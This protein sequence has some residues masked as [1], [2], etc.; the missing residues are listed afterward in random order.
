MLEQWGL[1]PETLYLNH[2]TV[3]ATPRRVLEAQHAIHREIER[4]PSRFM[5]RELTQIGHGPVPDRPRR[6]RVAAKAVAEFFNA[7]GDDLVFVDNATTGCNAVIQSQ[8]FQPG[9]EIVVTDLTY[10]AIFNAATYAARR[11]GAKVIRAEIPYPFR[12]DTARD[13]VL[14]VL[15]PK[16]KL[17]IVDHITSESALIMPLA[18]LVQRIHERGI[19][20]LVDAAHAPGAIAVDIPSFGADWYVGN[21]HKWAWAPRSSGILWCHPKRQAET[22]PTVISWGLDQGFTWEFDLVGTRDPSPYLAAPVALDFMRSLGVG[23][24]QAYNHELVWKAAHLLAERWGTEFTTPESMIGTMA[25]VPLPERV[26]STLDEV[27]ALRNALL[28]EGI[29]I[30][31]HAARGRCWARISA[32]IYNEMAD[33]ERLAESVLARLGTAAARRS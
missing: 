22:H 19:P 29:E 30:Q 33:Y 32:Q 18:E 11:A 6:I 4:H 5:L 20:V 24:V 10:G 26:G 15:T 23:A 13:A 31:M 28:V 16:T 7:A 14:A 2:G 3:G 27:R 17:A 1:E 8:T 12:P 9:D 21:L 25:T